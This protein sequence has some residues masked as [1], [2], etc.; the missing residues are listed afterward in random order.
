MT[1]TQNRILKAVVIVSSVCAAQYFIAPY[2]QD[3]AKKGTSA[4]LR[5]LPAQPLKPGV[6]AQETSQQQ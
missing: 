3:Q 6:Y 4:L 5:A 1:K 2:A